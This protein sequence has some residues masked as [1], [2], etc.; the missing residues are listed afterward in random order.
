VFVPTKLQDEF[1][2]LVIANTPVAAPAVTSPA[3]TTS[4]L[5]T[6]SPPPFE[7]FGT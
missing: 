6:V 5:F 1:A 2:P 7:I 3:R 4:N